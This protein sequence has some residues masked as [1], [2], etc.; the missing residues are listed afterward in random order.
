MCLRKKLICWGGGDILKICDLWVRSFWNK[1]CILK[2]K[3]VIGKTFRT[4]KDSITFHGSAGVGTGKSLWG[5]DRGLGVNLLCENLSS[6]IWGPDV[7]RWWILFSPKKQAKNNSHH[8]FFQYTFSKQSKL[9]WV[10]G[11]LIVIKFP[12]HCKG[13]LCHSRQQDAQKLV[14][15]LKPKRSKTVLGS[16]HWFRNGHTALFR[17]TRLLRHC[18]TL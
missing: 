12:L 1:C 18:V 2:N 4:L 15:F 14:S 17:P 5:R 3:S 7:T 8:L 9:V 16:F 13:L 11:C 10:I 6:R